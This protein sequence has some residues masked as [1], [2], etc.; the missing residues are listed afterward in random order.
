VKK[1][2]IN[3]ENNQSIIIYVIQFFVLIKLLLRY[4]RSIFGLIRKEYTI[5]RQNL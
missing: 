1:C 3:F 2:T 4:K 5:E